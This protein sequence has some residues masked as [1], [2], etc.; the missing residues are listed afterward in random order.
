MRIGL[1]VGAGFVLVFLDEVGREA[2]ANDHV[3]TVVGGMDAVDERLDFEAFFEEGEI[4]MGQG[5]LDG[6]KGDVCEDGT[7]GFCDGA[8]KPSRGGSVS[9]GCGVVLPCRS[10]WFT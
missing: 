4:D 2:A 8:K 1:L 7:E 10:L 9:G 5:V 3:D 6:G